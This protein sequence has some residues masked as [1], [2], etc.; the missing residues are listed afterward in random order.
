MDPRAFEAMA[1]VFPEDRRQA[2]ILIEI[3]EPRNLEEAERIIAGSG[4]RI[5][6]KKFL[7]PDWVLFTLDAMDCREIA[8]R[9]TEEGFEN[10]MGV[11]AIPD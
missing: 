8:L 3:I 5:L 10:I 2:Q 1:K 9:L 11:N 7:N 4:V 6:Q